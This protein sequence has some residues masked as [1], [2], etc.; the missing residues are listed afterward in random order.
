M[1]FG[2]QA[3]PVVARVTLPFVIENLLLWRDL[4]SSGSVFAAVTLLRIAMWYT[5]TTIGVALLY[6]GAVAVTVTLVWAQAGG[7]ISRGGPGVPD[8]LRQGL[9][10]VHAAKFVTAARAPANRAI[11][12]QRATGT[13][14]AACRHGPGP[15]APIV[16]AQPSRQGSSQGRG[17]RFPKA[18]GGSHHRRPIPHAT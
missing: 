6:M 14:R 18:G 5:Q 9:T 2:S 8:I 1:S 13:P 3:P 15:A 11:G 4:K 7:M 16:P 10:E 12:E 17:T